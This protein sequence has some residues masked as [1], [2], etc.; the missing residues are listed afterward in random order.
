MLSKIY[1]YRDCVLGDFAHW[2][3]FITV[4]FTL[5]FLLQ[6]LIIFSLSFPNIPCPSSYYVY[7]CF[8]KS[9]VI[10]CGFNFLNFRFSKM[11]LLLLDPPAQQVVW[12]LGN[13]PKRGK[14]FSRIRNKINKWAGIKQKKAILN[15]S[16][17]PF[18]H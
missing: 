17:R 5:P 15:V 8:A 4:V 14:N 10:E 12:V 3:V 11:S 6:P 13:Y 9:A 1:S 16:P 7:Y 2:E 18:L